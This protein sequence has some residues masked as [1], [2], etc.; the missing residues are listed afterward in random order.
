DGFV[1]LL[2]TDGSNAPRRLAPTN[3]I[4]ALT[5][6]PRS[7]RKGNRVA[8]SGSV[9]LDSTVHVH[10]AETGKELAAPVGHLAAVL[11]VACSPDGANVISGGSKG[12]ACLWDLDTVARRHAKDPWGQV[13]N[14]GFHPDGQWAFY[15]GNAIN[16]VH[17]FDVKTGEAVGPTFDQKHN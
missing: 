14:V 10:E 15:C 7:E 1:C 11:S 8:F 13:Y 17:F 5:F 2:D 16:N 3:G 12:R 6:L 9:L 4:F